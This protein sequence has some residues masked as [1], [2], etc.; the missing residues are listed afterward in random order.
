MFVNAGRSGMPSRLEV[1]K[2]G[3]KEVQNFGKAFSAGE[4]DIF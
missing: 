2:N 1:L 3:S 4:V